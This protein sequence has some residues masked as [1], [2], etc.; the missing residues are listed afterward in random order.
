[1]ALLQPEVYVAVPAQGGDEIVSN[2]DGQDGP[3]QQK[4]RNLATVARQ[5]RAPAASIVP[6]IKLPA[7]AIRGLTLGDDNLSRMDI[8]ANALNKIPGVACKVESEGLLNYENLSSIEAELLA[9]AGAGSQLGIIGHSMGADEV[10]KLA[11][12]LEDRHIKIAVAVSID[13]TNWDQPLA[14]CQCRRQSR[15]PAASF[16]TFR[17]AAAR[18]FS[19]QATRRQR[20]IRSVVRTRARPRSHKVDRRSDQCASADRVR[21][22]ARLP[23]TKIGGAGRVVANIATTL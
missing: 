2:T 7:V 4:A 3:L 20:S 10:W 21:Q 12:L 6:N 1:M 22:A 15:L 5:V 14:G 18:S 13:P 23:D 11:A 8:L 17:P 16:K 19:R 9:W